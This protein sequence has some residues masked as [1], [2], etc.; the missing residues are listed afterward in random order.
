MGTWRDLQPGWVDGVMGSNG[1]VAL[2]GTGVFTHMRADPSKIFDII[3]VDSVTDTILAAAVCQKL[4]GRTESHVP[5]VHA[6]S[7]STTPLLVKRFFFGIESY[8]SKHPSSTKQRQPVNIVVDQCVI[9]FQEAMSK[10]SKQNAKAAKQCIKANELFAPIVTQEWIF[11]ACRDQA[12]D[13]SQESSASE[14]GPTRA[15]LTLGAHCN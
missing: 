14:C 2:C 6:T 4:L 15:L 12:R 1:A 11:Q 7:S 5:I 10:E 9:D 8:F 13:V 3:P